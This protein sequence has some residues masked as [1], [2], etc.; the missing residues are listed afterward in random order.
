MDQINFTLTD[1]KLSY[2][3][4]FNEYDVRVSLNGI[5]LGDNLFNACSVIAAHKYN[6][7]EFHL[8]TCGCGV[9]G[10]AGYHT[11]VI[12]TKT[13]SVVNWKFPKDSSYKVDKL[14]YTFDTAQFNAEFKKIIFQILKLEKENTHLT[15]C[16]D[17]HDEFDEQ[18]PTGVTPFTV[19]VK[20][21]STHYQAI[22]NLVM[23]L[24][25]K[26][27]SLYNKSFY[28]KYGDE[29]T[30]S[31]YDFKSLLCRMVNH[32]PRK[33]KDKRFLDKIEKVGRMVEA[34]DYTSIIKT[35]HDAYKQFNEKS[36]RN[37]NESFWRTFQ[38]ELQSIVK[39]EDFDVK[40]VSIGYE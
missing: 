8:F 28:I 34:N 2:N 27:P 15:S 7:A 18:E 24:E 32:Y 20:W 1:S 5:S 9:P 19:G 3:K 17:F 35:V 22:Q 30:D 21:Y 11:E 33:V 38:W 14:E 6:F 4:K 16:V 10:C 25:E 23:M 39:E 37:K 31:E 29:V 12:Q 40:G 36:K 26:F 13:A